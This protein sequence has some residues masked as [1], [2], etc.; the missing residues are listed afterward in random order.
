[1]SEPK[2]FTN[3]EYWYDF[4]ERCANKKESEVNKLLNLEDPRL[5]YKAQGRI[6]MLEEVMKLRDKFNGKEGKNVWRKNN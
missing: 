1:M 3:S 6:E 2:L 4:V 5:I